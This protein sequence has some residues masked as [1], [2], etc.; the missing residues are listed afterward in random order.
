MLANPYRGAYGEMTHRKGVFWGTASTAAIAIPI[1]TTTSGSTFALY[2][3]PSSTVY[4]EPID[5]DLFLFAAGVASVT[6]VGWSIVN[7]VTN[8]FSA[9]TG[10]PGPIRAGGN[11]SNFSGGAPAGQ[12]CGAI[13]FASALTVAA[14]WGIGM[15]GFGVSA[16]P[17]ATYTMG[18]Y[19]YVFDGKLIIPPGWC[20][21]LTATAAWAAN[22]AVPQIFW[23]EY[24]I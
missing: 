24:P 20:I 21:T 19:H 15:Y 8:A 1:N 17:T 3:P 18:P 7:S 12:L 23:A 14:N 22:T 5:F 4:L 13:T 16:L 11:P 6:T 10:N 9:I 2:N